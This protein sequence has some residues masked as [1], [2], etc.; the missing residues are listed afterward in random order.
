M[1]NA[2]TTKTLRKKK[3]EQIYL[4]ILLNKINK[5]TDIY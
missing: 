3:Y 5:S 2:T 1:T 4:D